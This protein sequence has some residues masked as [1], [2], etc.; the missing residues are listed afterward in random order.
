MFKVITKGNPLEVWGTGF[1]TREKAQKRVD[2]GYFH[3]FM[4]DK[5]KGKNLEVVEE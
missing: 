1:R 4:Y 3:R 2:E 5:D